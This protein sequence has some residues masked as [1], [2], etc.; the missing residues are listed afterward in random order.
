MTRRTRRAALLLLLPALAA[1]AWAP[2]RFVR[3][4]PHSQINFLASSRLIDAQGTWDSWEADVTFDP[5]A[6]NA[7]SVAIT[8]QAKSINTRVEMRDNHLRS[9]DFFFADSFPSITFKSVSVKAPSGVT[10]DPELADTK[11]LITG[12]LTIRGVT[13]RITVPSTL[14]FYDRAQQR[15]RVKGAFTVLR[16][17]Y[18]VG[19]DP[20]MNP[21][22]NE[23]ELTFDISF[24]AAK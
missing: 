13:K 3:D 1:A 8:I 12:D 10:K 20:P 16:K 5:D 18:G 14:M 24:Q 22:R 11:L 2:G 15:G 4:V 21:V 6:I 23:V 17:D 7:S 19:F 9:K